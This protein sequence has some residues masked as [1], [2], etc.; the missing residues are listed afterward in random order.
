MLE[1]KNLLSLSSSLRRFLQPFYVECHYKLP[2]RTRKFQTESLRSFKIGH[3]KE[4]F[5]VDNLVTSVNDVTEL[6]QLKSQSIEIMKG[7]I[8]LHCWASNDSKEDQDMQMVLG[9]SWNVVSDELSYKLPSNL[10][11]TQERPVTKG[12]CYM[13]STVYTIRLAFTAPALLLPKLLMQEAW[14]GKIG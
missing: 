5:Y 13:E 10:D 14:R 4:R 9:L 12:Y 6:E 7:A 1:N 8:E 3:L 11:C 2:S